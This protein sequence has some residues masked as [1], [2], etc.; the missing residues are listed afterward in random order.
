M[1]STGI[2]ISVTDWD[3]SSRLAPGTEPHPGVFNLNHT[4]QISLAK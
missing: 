3:R 2:F 4:Y 1:G